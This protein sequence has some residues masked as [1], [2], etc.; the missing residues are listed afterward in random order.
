MSAPFKLGSKKV[1]LPSTIFTLVRGSGRLPANQAMFHVPLK[2]NKFDVR[3]YL[4]NLYGLVTTSVKT[5]IQQSPLQRGTNKQR[6]R[7]L[8]FMKPLQMTRPAS[9]KRVIVTM[10]QPFTY[11]E[12]YASAESLKPWNVE[13]SERMRQRAMSGRRGL[14]RGKM[15]RFQ[16]NGRSEK[17][18]AK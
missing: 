15:T 18:L 4:F 7:G 12:A 9:S 1:Y 2:V 8:H 5:M 16:V 13:M 3:D 14:T 6:A 11:P 17:R 10:E